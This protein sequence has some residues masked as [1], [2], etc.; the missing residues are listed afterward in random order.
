MLKYIKLVNEVKSNMESETKREIAE[1]TLNERDG[2]QM[3][4]YTY[5]SV[6][7]GW[8][9]GG[10]ACVMKWNGR[11]IVRRIAGGKM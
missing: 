1:I 7:S 4:I 6:E 10:A 9:N 3:A 2:Q 11:D 5:G 8:L